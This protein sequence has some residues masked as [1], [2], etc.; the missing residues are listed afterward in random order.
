MLLTCVLSAVALYVAVWRWTRRA[1]AA[2]VAGTLFALAPSQL[3]VLTHIQVL[4]IIY[5]PLVLLA[6][7]EVLAGGGWGWALGLASALLL[8]ALCSAYLGALGFTVALAIL[9]AWF[10]VGERVTRS[11]LFRFV[12]AVGVAAIIA[13]VVYQ[14]YTAL[15]HV[16][17]IPDAPRAVQEAFSASPLASYV[18]GLGA[19]GRSYR[20][21]SL[22]A[23]ILALCGLVASRRVLGAVEGAVTVAQVRAAAVAIGATG[24]V[25]S[26]GPTLQLTG[27]LGVPLPFRLV[28]LV[29]GL[30]ALRGPARF[31][32]L[33]VLAASVL[34]A[35]GLAAIVDLRRRRWT[36]AAIIV[37]ALGVFAVEIAAFSFPL[38]PVQ[39]GRNV[40][41]VYRWLA[42]HGGRQPVLELPVGVDSTEYGA[43]FTQSRYTYFSSYHWSPLLNGYSAYPPD[44]FFFLMEIARRLPARDALHDLVSLTGLRWIVLHGGALGKAARQAWERPV[45]GLV[46]AARFEEDVVF[47]VQL[48]AS[49]DLRAK[50]AW[51]AADEVTLSGLTVRPILPAAMRGAL[52][53][54]EIP[55]VL[56]RE[57]IVQGWVTLENQSQ[58]TWPGFRPAPDG[59]IHLGYRWLDAAG[60]PLRMSP[61]LTRVPV[62]LKPGERVRVPFSIEPPGE[63]GRY[64]LRVTVVQKGGA[65]FDEHGGPTV[66]RDVAVR[67]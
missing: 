47:E 8:Q 61:R 64:R 30:S 19:G 12:G 11:G 32:T 48:A 22:S 14:P 31:G 62:D 13:A 39:A 57:W 21:L 54:L 49:R 60:R 56:E 46:V 18:P 27:D 41:P 16:G 25:L 34:A 24:Y 15:Q 45:D 66:E 26:L 1:D 4:P 36:G 38:R 44:S 7:L 29:P 63:P 40:P 65:W 55:P 42:D 58:H 43:M 9:L 33:V 37:V 23:A 5:L 50:L 2:F 67:P 53:D 51:P 17:G 3:H 20:F 59:L 6:G 10:L 35:L 28:R 52:R